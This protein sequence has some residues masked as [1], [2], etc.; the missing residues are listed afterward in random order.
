[1]RSSATRGFARPL[2]F[3]GPHW[4]LGPKTP[5]VI[6]CLITGGAL[7]EPVCGSS[8]IDPALPVEEVWDR[9]DYVGHS[10]FT[11]T[12][13]DGISV[14]Q[15]TPDGASGLYKSVDL[16]TMV[17]PSVHWRWRSDR[18]Q[19]SADLRKTETEDFSGVVFFVFGE[20]SLI[21][22]NVPTLAYAWTATPVAI[23]SII[24]NPRHPNTLVTIKLEGPPTVG[25]WREETRNLRADYQ[26]AF[27]REPE[28][29]LRYV[30]LF[31][32]DDQTHE[33]SLTYYGAVT[34]SE[35]ESKDRAP[36]DR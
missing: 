29:H 11:N 7:A 22:P 24:R 2:T 33:A 14:I 25:S 12:I 5:F 4:G 16:D 13:K 21:H 34:L 17:S 18:L 32:D 10:L 36:G 28:D 26:A 8:L 9:H 35:C 30:A 31:S 6:L 15:A 3:A 23:G 20:P 27:G 19:P 1:M